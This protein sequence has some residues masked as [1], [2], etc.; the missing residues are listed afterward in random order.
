[1][2]ILIGIGLI[3]IN[4]WMDGWKGTNLGDEARSKV[5]RYI[6]QNPINPPPR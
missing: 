5:Q 2:E 6:T 1:M 3:K 4:S